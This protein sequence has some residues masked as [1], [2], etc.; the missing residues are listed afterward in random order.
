[1]ELIHIWRNSWKAYG[2][3]VSHISTQL[4]HMSHNLMLRTYLSQ[5]NGGTFSETPGTQVY[6]FI[7]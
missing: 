6:Q 4:Q 7:V 5:V 2:F 3:K 1:M